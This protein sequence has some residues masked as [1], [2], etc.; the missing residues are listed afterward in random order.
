[1][2]RAVTLPEGQLEGKSE[3]KPEGKPEEE[4]ED[5]ISVLTLLK[6]LNT[7]SYALFYCMGCTRIKSI[8]GW[9]YPWMEWTYSNVPDSDGLVSDQLDIYG[10]LY[11]ASPLVAFVPGILSFI[12]L[13]LTRKLGFKT[14]VHDSTPFLDLR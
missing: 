8:Q 7:W 9:I 11:L 1:M 6:D 14:G 13:K 5:K 4:K 2:E 10:Y 3:E 12:L